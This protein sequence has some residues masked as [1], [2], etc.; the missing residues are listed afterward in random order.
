MK[1]ECLTFFIKKQES[2]IYKAE[3]ILKAQM[4]TRY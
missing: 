3:E 2:K 4:N 1:K